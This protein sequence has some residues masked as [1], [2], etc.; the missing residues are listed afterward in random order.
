LFAACWPCNE[1]LPLRD[2]E[3]GMDGEYYL[4]AHVHRILATYTVYK[5]L[6]AEYAVLGTAV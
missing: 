6:L 3:D 2:N 1:A 5:A 4:V